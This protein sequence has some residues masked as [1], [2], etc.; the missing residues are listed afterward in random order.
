MDKDESPDSFLITLPRTWMSGMPLP[1]FVSMDVAAW[2]SR[3]QKTPTKTNS[4]QVVAHSRSSLLGFLRMLTRRLDFALPN[5]TYSSLSCRITLTQFGGTHSTL[6]LI[7]TIS[8]SSAL[9]R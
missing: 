1:K 3:L 8:E 9:D 4:L 6:D 2:I 5:I 7:F